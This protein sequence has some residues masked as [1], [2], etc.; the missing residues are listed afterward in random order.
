MLSPLLRRQLTL[1]CTIIILSCLFPISANT[2]LA[3]ESATYLPLIIKPF[4]V[5]PFQFA[6]SNG[7]DTDFS[8]PVGAPA[9]FPQGI[10]RL[11]AGSIV[12]GGIGHPW[13]LEWTI[14]GTCATGLDE[15]GTISKS[16]EPIGITIFYGTSGQCQKAIPSG[17]Y[18]VRLYVSDTLFQ[19][20][21]ATIQ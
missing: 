1:I 20:A 2:A 7:C 15:N 10:K 16:P 6:T 9:T 13:R 17:T 8:D 5:A 11:F 21:T 14:N 12:E 4:T 3:Q 19:A 18:E